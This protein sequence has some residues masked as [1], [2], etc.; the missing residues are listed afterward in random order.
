ML[1]SEVNPLLLA[2]GGY[3]IPR[4][5]RFRSGASG[6]FNRT[7]ASASSRTTWTWSGWVK[8]GEMSRAG[9]G[10]VIGIFGA[11]TLGTSQAN[12]VCYFNSNY[13]IYLQETVMNVSNQLIYETT[14]F[15]RD[16]SAWYHIIIAMD[17]TQATATN[18]TKIYVN[19]I[20]APGAFS[21]T[22]GQNQALSINNNVPQ[23]VGGA[24]VN[25]QA[26][27][28]VL[29]YFD[30]YI[31]EINF[32]DGQQLTPSSFGE[33]DISTG[34]WK[35]KKYRG[36]YGTNGYYLN[37]SNNS[38]STATTIGAD[39]SGNGNNWTPNN[40]SVTT[41]VSYDSML[42]VPTPYGD[43]GNGRGNY[44]MLNPINGSQGTVSNGNLTYASTGNNTGFQTRIGT[45][46]GLSTG[47]WYFEVTITAASA[48]NSDPCIGWLND[49]FGPIASTNADGSANA[50]LVKWKNA[51]TGSCLKQN[52]GTATTIFSATAVGDVVMI[53]IAID[54]LKIWMGKNGVWAESGV[55]ATDT[56][57]QFTNLSGGPFSPFVRGS[58]AG[59][60]TSTLDANFGQ[61]PFAYT[62]PTGFNTLNTFYLPTPTIPKGNKHFDI[63]TY[64]GV[65]GSQTLTGLN[66]A[67]DF[68]W[69][70]S[71]STVVDN[72]VQSTLLTFT[73]STAWAGFLQTNTTAIEQ[74][75]GGGDYQNI[76]STGY[77]VVADNSR[78]GANGQTYVTW[79]WNGGGSTATNTTGTISAQ[80]RANPTAGF[81]VLTY[82]GTG[83][84]ATVGHGLNAAPKMVIVKNRSVVAS[85][86]V[87][88]SSFAG[89]EYIVLESQA[90]K[91]S[92]AAMWNS[93]IPTSTVINLGTNANTNGSTNK[94][95]AYCWSEVAGYS[96]FGTYT[97]NGV[98]DG[99]FVYLGFRPRFMLIKR[100]DGV[101]NWT[102]WDSNRN[103]NNTTTSE[104]YPNLTNAEANGGGLTFVSNGMKVSSVPG[105]NYNT[106]NATYMYAAFAENP[107]KYSLA[108]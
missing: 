39:S 83:A 103:A 21:V 53:A 93:A 73:G 75:T 94:F 70:K 50:W 98:A 17:T 64:T 6:Y 22:P 19:G 82:T 78:T 32:V 33:T 67:P 100:T 60:T 23:Y 92:L 57:A 90:A 48:G 13:D 65:T 102:I 89:T 59:S 18:R 4:S 52:G 30:G 86:L 104:L 71:R 81:S 34:V 108:R 106:T 77:D 76:T 36:T 26:Y 5:V 79:N 3:Q 69:G 87:W 101:D 45:I 25:P 35:P 28:N 49:S 99:P 7:P 40:I 97:G 84:N 68:I 58:G 80:V 20:Q 29:S 88:H 96:K 74:N 38:A 8:R 95:V 107:F 54:G 72:H 41:G 24:G 91:T 10:G 105:S 15:Y 27:G 62:P 46:G 1:P 44:C 2:G 42:D 16:P 63:L 43:G 14:S 47:K 51:S 66:F 37:F 31:T 11:G 12:F 55:P 9:V 56:N 85:W 61:R